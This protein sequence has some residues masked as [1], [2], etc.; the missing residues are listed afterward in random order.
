M[1]AGKYEQRVGIFS[2]ELIGKGVPLT[3]DYQMMS[4]IL[5]GMQCLCGSTECKEFIDRAQYA[6][7]RKV[8]AQQARTRARVAARDAEPKPYMVDRFLQNDPNRLGLLHSYVLVMNLFQA[9]FQNPRQ[10]IIT[11]L[12]NHLEKHYKGNVHQHIQVG[13]I[14]VQ[15]ELFACTVTL[16]GVPVT[17][18]VNKPL[19]GRDAKKKAYCEAITMWQQLPCMELGNQ[20]EAQIHNPLHTV[21]PVSYSSGD[22]VKTLD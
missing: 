18:V 20:S 10:D 11:L 8:G 1:S 13:K 12:H 21:L 7:R 2:L 5:F 3:I 4:I 16:F 9:D 15:G 19:N 6:I 22:Y 17:A 14:S